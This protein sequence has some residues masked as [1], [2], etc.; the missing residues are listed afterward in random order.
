[1]A[2]KREPNEL[3]TALLL[4]RSAAGWDQQQLARALGVSKSWISQI[5]R[6]DRSPS[7]ATLSSVAVALGLP[8]SL[9]DQARALAREVI[10]VRAAEV[11]SAADLK[12]LPDS[13]RLSSALAGPSDLAARIVALAAAHHD[14]ALQVHGLEVALTPHEARH[15]AAGLWER[16][17]RWPPSSLH[18]LVRELPELWNW[19]LCERLCEESAR[20]AANCAADAIGLA[21]L[22]L[23]LAALVP[24][25]GTWRLR[26]A[27]YAWAF[28]GNARRVANELAAAEEA[29]ARSRELWN[30]GA[31]GD[32]S[33][34]LDGTR[35]LDLEASLRRA[36]R[37]LPEALALLDRAL[38]YRPTGEGRARLLLNKAKTLEELGDHSKAIVALRDAT[39]LLGPDAE[40]RLALVLRFNLAACLLHVGASEEADP[41]LAE[42]RLLT[43][44]LG[45]HLDLLRLRGLEGRAAAARGHLAKAT[46]AFAEIAHEFASRGMDYDAA[47]CTIEQATLLLD[48]GR[49]AEVKKLARQSGPIFR[50]KGVHRE[51]RAALELFRRA[52]EQETVTVVLAQELT[53]YLAKARQ[54]SKLSFQ[55]PE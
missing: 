42:A 25:S 53:S 23:D 43:A 54:D 2:A 7:S 6:G 16:I 41:H 19:A 26:L 39:P 11:P 37:R 33:L 20:Q 35:L 24:G 31:H 28:V 27:G 30:L 48:Q 14:K 49:T 55:F 13:R 45:N 46:V 4:L 18:R 15:R 40:P 9:L 44:K 47:L 5:E 36:Q 38:T 34:L 3:G 12:G 10:E 32:R 50:A 21:D 1:M 8:V 17:Q 52:A 22:A 29:F 51:A